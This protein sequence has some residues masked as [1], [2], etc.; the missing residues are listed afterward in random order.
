[1]VNE[2]LDDVEDE[3]QAAC[4]TSVAAAQDALRGL[5]ATAASLQN[6]A[7]NMAA[8]AILCA[9]SQVRGQSW[10]HVTVIHLP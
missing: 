4:E 1:M 2:A 3:L 5:A 6:A 8:A 9:M 10:M 7:I